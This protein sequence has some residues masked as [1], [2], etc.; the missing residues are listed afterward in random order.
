MTLRVCAAVLIL[1]STAA[2]CETNPI[3]PAPSQSLPAQD[4]PQQSAAQV[5]IRDF[6]VRSGTEAV[7]GHF[8]YAP[9]FTL[10]E[11][12]GISPARTE[13]IRFELLDI[14]IHGT[15]PTVVDHI[16]V[17]A[18]G[19]VTLDL[20]VYGGDWFYITNRLN[21]PRLAVTVAYADHSGRPGNVSAV[22]QIQR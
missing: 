10:A 9:K 3:A 20:D 16:E 8:W 17:P 7:S 5:E 11:T 22:T 6:V 4:P 21:A 14:G 19:T 18:G 13:W 15:V 2:G 1:A 12:S